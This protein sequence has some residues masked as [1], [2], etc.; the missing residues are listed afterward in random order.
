MISSILA[1]ITAYL[2]G[3][4]S[5][6][7][8][9]SRAKGQDV[10]EKD[11]AGTSGMMRQFG[12]VG[13]T[14]IMLADILKGALAAFVANQI[15]NEVVWFAPAAATLGHCY[16]IWH[17]FKGGQGV[18][19]ACGALTVCSSLIGLLT[20]ALGTLIIVLHRIFKLKPFV[21]LGAVPFSVIVTMPVMFVTVAAREGRTALIGYVLIVVVMV[22]RGAQVLLTPKPGQS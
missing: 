20:I 16:P 11:F 4:I 22:A 8:I 2:I 19:P 21:K 18:A 1:L 12:V 10:R 15:S 13:G 17:G 6:A 14:G 5:P 3:A 9:Y 7:I